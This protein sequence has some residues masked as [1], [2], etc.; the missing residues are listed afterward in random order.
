[1]GL[2]TTKLKKHI[3]IQLNENYR[4][5]IKA[6]KECGELNVATKNSSFKKFWWDT[7]LNCAKTESMRAHS[8]WVAAGKP[9]S[10]DIFN[11]RNRN[12]LK[13]R[14]LIKNG[15]LNEKLLVTNKLTNCLCEMHNMTEFW[16]I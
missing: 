13:Y 8:A 9:R 10:G 6:L 14:M 2:I 4:E 15:K 16:K 5:L 1:M 11:D 12:K 7:E 3:Q